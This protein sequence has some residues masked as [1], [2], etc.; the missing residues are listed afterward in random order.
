VFI[1]TW[2]SH[3]SG[4]GEFYYPS[5]VAVGSNGDIY[6]ADSWNSRVQRFDMDGNF[7]QVW[8]EEGLDIGELNHPFDLTIGPDDTVYVT[9]SWNNRIQQFSAT[10]E[11]VR[12][13]GSKGTTSGQFRR[14]CGVAVG[15]DGTVY[16]ADT[17]NG[18]V[19]QFTNDGDFVRAWSAPGGNGEQTSV[20]Y[21]VTTG[22]DGSIYVT[23][24]QFHLIQQFTADGVF[25]QSWGGFGHRRGQ[26]TKPIGVAVASD[27]NVFVA[28]SNNDCVQVFGRSVPAGWRGEYHANRWL[29]EA[30][31]LVRQDVKVDFDWADGSPGPGVPADGFSVRWTRYLGPGA[32]MYRF[33]LSANG[34]V[35]FWVDDRLLFDAWQDTEQGPFQARVDLS[36]GYHWLRLDYYDADG[37]A[38]VRLAWER[39][40]Y[41]LYLPLS[42]FQRGKANL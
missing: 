21:G 32:G 40:S 19:Q 17:D 3:G 23:D 39:L 24:L 20:P 41:R 10:G 25:V 28:D 14:P 22:P 34:G 6:V 7:L 29:T 38:A 2:G 36:D 33:T 42:L 31:V 8:G 11:F 35:R 18:R 27:G 30:P 1:R 37:L 13:W 16:V 26:L 15:L 5:G 12:V 4:D 9:D